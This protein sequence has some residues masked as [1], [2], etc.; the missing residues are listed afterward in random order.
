[1][2][3]I[4]LNQLDNILIAT[5]A[6]LPNILIGV[7]VFATIIYFGKAVNKVVGKFLA[8]SDVLAIHFEIYLK[9]SKIFFLFIAIILFLN[10]VGLKSISAGLFAGG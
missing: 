10:I 9:I 5:I 8:R 2:K 1:M 3:E 7:S 4:L 6:V